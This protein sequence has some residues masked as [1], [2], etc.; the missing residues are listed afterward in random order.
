MTLTEEQE[1]ELT[2]IPSHLWSK[3]KA[4]VG[5]I[6]GVEPVSITA[7][8]SFR[9][10]QRQY[11]LKSEAEPEI[12]PIIKDLLKAEVIIECPESPCNIPLFPVKKTA[13]SS[14]W[15]MVQDLQEMQKLMQQQN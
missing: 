12:E 5:L 7:K 8:T 3:G 9:L 1:K 4:D 11:P 14:G 13:P 2:D 15:R 10:H 6:K